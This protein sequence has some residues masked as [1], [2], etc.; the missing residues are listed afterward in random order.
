MMRPRMPH[1][2][3]VLAAVPLAWMTISADITCAESQARPSLADLQAQID[4]LVAQVTALQGQ[5]DALTEVADELCALYIQLNDDGTIDPTSVPE[6]CL[7]EK[8]VFVTSGQYTGDLGGLAGADVICQS[9]AEGAGLTGTYKAWLSD[10]TQGAAARM[11]HSMAAYVTLQG[12]VIAADWDDLVDGQIAHP[13]DVDET[14]ASSIALVWT[15]TDVDGSPFPWGVGPATDRQCSNWTY[16][17]P[18]YLEGLAT[19]RGYGVVGSSSETSGGWT[20]DFSLPGSDECD[21]ERS[22]YCVEQ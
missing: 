1:G 19:L 7:Q 6:R 3:A 4:Q 18:E 2:L 8:V 15:G 12:D 13:I 14:G 17:G 21:R 10:S 11:T 9:T 16:D 22:L 20:A 5:V